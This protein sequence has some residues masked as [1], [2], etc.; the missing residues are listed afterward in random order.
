LSNDEIDE[1]A[2]RAYQKY[3]ARPFFLLKHT[4]KVRSWAEFRRKFF[5]FW[6]MMLRQESVSKAD[7]A[8]KCYGED[9]GR[10][11]GYK[12]ISKWSQSF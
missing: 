11:D 10:L 12:K 7:H 3:H 1:L 5:A 6:E 8:F 4:L 2:L 9:K